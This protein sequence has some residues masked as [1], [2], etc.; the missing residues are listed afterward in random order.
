VGVLGPFGVCLYWYT[1]FAF[2]GMLVPQEPAEAVSAL[3]TVVS[4]VWA[5]ITHLDVR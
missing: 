3:L 4:I 1:L 2:L 5:I